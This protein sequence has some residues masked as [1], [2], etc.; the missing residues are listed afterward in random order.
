MAGVMMLFSSN[1]SD[2]QAI[3]KLCATTDKRLSRV[4]MRAPGVSTVAAGSSSFLQRWFI[5]TEV[6]TNTQLILSPYWTVCAG[7]ASNP[8]VNRPIM[9]NAWRSPVQSRHAT[10]RAPTRFFHALRSTQPPVRTNRHRYSMWF[11]YLV[12]SCIRLGIIIWQFQCLTSFL[13]CVK[14]AVIRGSGSRWR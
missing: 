13:R 4:Q 1:Q 11:S 8:V 7:L 9:P 10:L 5:Q 14:S 3:S 6:S 2:C 12:Y